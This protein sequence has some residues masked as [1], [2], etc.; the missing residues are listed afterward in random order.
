MKENPS[1]DRLN[2]LTE[3]IIGCAFTVSNTLGAGFLEKV[4]EN[5]MAFELRKAGLKAEQQKPIKVHYENVIVGDYV[6]DIVVDDVILVE[7]KAIRALDD[8]H[9][10][11]CMNYLKATNLTICLLLNFGVAKIQIK[12]IVNNL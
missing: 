4:Y 9:M 5:A 2:A 8:T 6:A 10:S 7:L 11:Q 3:K 12:R 1:A